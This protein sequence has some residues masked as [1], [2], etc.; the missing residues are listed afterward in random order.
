MIARTLP[1][2]IFFLQSFSRKPVTADVEKVTLRLCITHQ[3]W[4]SLNLLLLPFQV[5]AWSMSFIEALQSQK[6]NSTGAAHERTAN[7]QLGGHHL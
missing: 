6:E 3:M 2:E 7:E 5:L 4:L 1:E